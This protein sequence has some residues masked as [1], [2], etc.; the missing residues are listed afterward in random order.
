M[1][2]LVSNS[3]Y[4]LRWDMETTLIP[5]I[6]VHSTSVVITSAKASNAYEWRYM[7]P[8]YIII[9]CLSISGNCMVIATLANN[10]RMRTAVSDFL[11][12]VLC[13]PFTLIGQYYRRFLFGAAM[14]K[15]IPFLQA[16]SLERYFAIC[17]PLKSRKWQTQCHAYKMIATVWTLS[18]IL[19]SPILLV[20][21]LQPMR[22]NGK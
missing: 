3:S 19:N 6:A 13:L 4:L 2:E 9:F 20:S 18:F 21:R 14:C 16:I 17:R 22:G 15:L 7:L 12:G 11:L 5:F 8:P 1:E 10:R